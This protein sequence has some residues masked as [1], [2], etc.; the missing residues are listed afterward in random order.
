MPFGDSNLI[1]ML[2]YSLAIAFG[3][4]LTSCGDSSAPSR[5]TVTAPGVR[6]ASF[7]VEGGKATNAQLKQGLQSAAD[8]L[9][10][11]YAEARKTHPQLKG[12]LR[13]IFHIEPDGKVR[14]FAERNSEFT[15]AEGKSLSQDFIGATFGGKW[16]F[17]RLGSDLMITIDFALEPGI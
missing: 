1:A 6:L 2:R 5:V 3:L 13:G 11:V 10:K 8:A 14:L 9:S 16:Q 7:K 4:A 17:P 15:P 12:H